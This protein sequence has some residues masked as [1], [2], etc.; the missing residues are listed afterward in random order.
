MSDSSS[1]L[2]DA[3]VTAR[4]STGMTVEQVSAATNLRPA[5]LR[6]LEAGDLRPCGGPVYARGHVRSI[7]KALGLDAAP[8]VAALD[9]QAGAPAAPLLTSSAPLRAEP[10]S[11]RVPLAARPER[12]GPHWGVA[13]AAALGVLVV[14]LGVGLVSDPRERGPEPLDQLAGPVAVP[15]RPAPAPK[16]LASDAKAAAPRPTGAALRV[17]VT[18]GSSWISV[19]NAGGT[20]FEGV[21]AQGQPP[22]DFAD[23]K[24]LKLVVG[25]AAAVNVICSGKDLGAAGGAGKVR[26]F[27]CSASGLVPA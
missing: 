2:G 13:V 7:A 20:L 16:P 1:P 26:R 8:L 17:R 4:E 15:P 24:Q 27:T 19:S 12:R 23:P 18:S 6:S 21:L 5:L 10:G 25:N 14:L 9:A 3:L 22:R 11:L